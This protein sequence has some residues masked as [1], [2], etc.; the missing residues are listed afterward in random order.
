AFLLYSKGQETL[1][2]E[3]FDR[4]K[5]EMRKMGVEVQK[6]G[7]RALEQTLSI[8]SDRLQNDLGEVDL[9]LRVPTD[10]G[11][12]LGLAAVKDAGDRA[13]VSWESAVKRRAVILAPRACTRA[14]HKGQFL[15]DAVVR[16]HGAAAGAHVLLD[17]QHP[18][19]PWVGRQDAIE[20][21]AICRSY[22]DCCPRYLGLRRPSMEHAPEDF[23]G[24]ARSSLASWGNPSSTEAEKSALRAISIHSLHTTQAQVRHGFREAEAAN[25]SRGPRS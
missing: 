20:H 11:W 19:H 4:M 24:I 18:E 1:D 21:Y 2:P 13:A 15:E 23:V 14:C 6:A 22:H 8:T 12:A 17:I 25:V 3:T 5:G 9:I 16:M 7:S 10:V